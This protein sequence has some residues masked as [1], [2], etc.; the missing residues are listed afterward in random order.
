MLIK[1]CQPLPG[2]DGEILVEPVLGNH[3]KI[4]VIPA[5]DLIN[6][7]VIIKSPEFGGSVQAAALRV[8]LPIELPSGRKIVIGIIQFMQREDAEH[9]EQQE[10]AK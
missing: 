4:V 5:S 8:I 6:G 10:D 9:A 3:F 7:L 1:V 2:I